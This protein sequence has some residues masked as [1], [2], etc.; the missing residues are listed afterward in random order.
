M[1]GAD[2]TQSCSRSW[3]MMQVSDSSILSVLAPSAALF[4]AAAPRPPLG[5][6][7]A[8][9]NPASGRPK[10]KSLSA[11]ETGSE[12]TREHRTPPPKWRERETMKGDEEIKSD[13]ERDKRLGKERR[14]REAVTE[15]RDG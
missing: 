15:G 6:L 13:R 9:L 3:Q 14:E 10:S 4:P 11:Q 5:G 7:S 8:S 2:L 1:G 12:V